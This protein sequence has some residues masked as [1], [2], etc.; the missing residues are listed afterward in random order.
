MAWPH[1]A[2]VAV[3]EMESGYCLES[4]IHHLHQA[5]FAAENASNDASASTILIEFM[6]ELIIELSRQKSQALLYGSELIQYK[7]TARI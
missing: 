4:I 2:H 1:A 3:L 6:K 5:Y 7:D